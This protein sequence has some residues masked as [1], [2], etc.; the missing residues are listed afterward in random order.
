MPCATPVAIADAKVQPVPCVARV[1]MRCEVNTLGYPQAALLCLSLAM[2]CYNLLGAVKAAVRQEQG[3]KAEE[4]LSSY[5]MADE[6]RGTYRGMDIATPDED[7]E[8][9]RQAPV[10]RSHPTQY[11]IG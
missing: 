1:A 4:K 11:G 5:Y 6:V 9:F 8:Q 3:P 10:A 2:C 7:W